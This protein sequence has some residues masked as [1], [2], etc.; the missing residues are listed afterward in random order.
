MIIEMAPGEVG[1]AFHRASGVS[2]VKIE[3]LRNYQ[4]RRGR[5]Y[6]DRLKRNITPVRSS[7][8]TPVKYAP[9][10]LMCPS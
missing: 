10:S 9:L 2:R 7:G 1:F 4:K 3:E 6:A 8:P 5:R